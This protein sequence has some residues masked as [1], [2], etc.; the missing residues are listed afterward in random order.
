MRSID[1]QNMKRHNIGINRESY[2]SKNMANRQEAQR[3]T[4][5]CLKRNFV[6]LSKTFENYI[7]CAIT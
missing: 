7:F 1:S 2:C 4:L 5:S 3:S 6:A